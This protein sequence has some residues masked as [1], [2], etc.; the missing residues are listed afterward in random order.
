MKQL[1]VRQNKYGYYL[2]FTQTNFDG[3]V[4]DSID[5]Y[6]PYLKVWIQG[7]PSEVLL[8]GEG[9]VVNAG[10]GTWR[11]LVKDGDFP[12]V[13]TFDGQFEYTSDSESDISSKTFSVIVEESP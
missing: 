9:E 2:E 7:S 10:A 13:G 1:T 11:Y 12:V 6:T 8:S 5:E 3:S 4:F